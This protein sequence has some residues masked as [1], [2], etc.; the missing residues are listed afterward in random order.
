MQSFLA[1]RRTIQGPFLIAIVLFS[2]NITVDSKSFG[3]HL[4]QSTQYLYI[5]YPI[6]LHPPKPG[7]I[8]A[9]CS[10]SFQKSYINGI[11]LD[12]AFQ[13]KDRFFSFLPPFARRI[14]LS[15]PSPANGDLFFSLNAFLGVPSFF[16]IKKHT[17]Y[18]TC[19]YIPS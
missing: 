7:C 6:F 18:Q 15:T 13:M 3:L 17:S 9:M 4:R 5:V 8:F 19:V 2:I 14:F 16:D 10:E 11:T 12:D 1:A